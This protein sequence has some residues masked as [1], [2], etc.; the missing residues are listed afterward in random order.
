[1][2]TTDE[3]PTT[4]PVALPGS[5]ASQVDAPP[6]LAPP[7]P[8]PRDLAIGGRLA[9]ELEPLLE[10]RPVASNPPGLRWVREQIARRLGV[11]GFDVQRLG[12]SGQASALVAHRPGRG[13]HLALSAH[14]DVEQEGEGWTLAPFTPTLRDG[15]LFGRGTADNLGPLTLRLLA[16]GDVQS[17]TPALTWV[18]QGEEEI[19]SPL[20]HELYPALRLPPV[21]LWIEETGYFERN[22]RQ[23]MLMCRPAPPTRRLVESLTRVAATHGRGVDIHDR[24]L[25]KAFGADRC[26]VLSHLVGEA[27]YVAFGPNDPDSRI[28]RPDESLPLAN[29]A[30]AWDQFEAALRTAATLEGA[31]DGDHTLSLG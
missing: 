20:A 30:V 27:P 29:L 25:N 10:A 1:M 6:S 5:T 31:L 12:E 18:I 14:Y 24:V 4:A 9:A 21:D 26:P 8:S 3:S 15:R 16:L 13:L 19:G 23:R 17:E 22:G 11:L 28:H 2:N 7:A